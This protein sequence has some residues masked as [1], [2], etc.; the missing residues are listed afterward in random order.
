MWALLQ[1]LWTRDYAARLPAR[2]RRAAA[3]DAL[4]P[5]SPLVS[6]GR[7]RRA[8]LRR[9]APRH[10]AGGGRRR[11][12][13]PGAHAGAARRGVHYRFAARCRRIPRASRARRARRCGCT[14]GDAHAAKHTAALTRPRPASA[15]LCFSRSGCG[16]RVDAA[17]R[18]GRV[19]AGGA[20][21]GAARRR[22]RAGAAAGADGICGAHERMK[23]RAWLAET[24][25]SRATD[26]G[27]Q[28]ALSSTR[29]PRIRNS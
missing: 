16:C 28:R 3:A 10:G 26:S 17:G 2:S 13:P 25:R 1:A 18:R 15:P 7:V 14:R 9:L 6:S 4:T 27:R 29:P 12:R 24:L 8:R 21:A 22:R 11:R 19:A 5:R 20:A 23:D